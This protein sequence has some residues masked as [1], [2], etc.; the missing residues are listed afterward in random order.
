VSFRLEYTLNAQSEI[1]D[2]YL[3]IKERAPLALN[4][5]QLGD[6]RQGDGTLMSRAW[7]GT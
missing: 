7:N 2:S 1:E 6:G 3:W 4:F 5:A